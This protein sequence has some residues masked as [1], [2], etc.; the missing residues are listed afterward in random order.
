MRST[1]IAFAVATLPLIGG[2]P[3]SA[4]PASARSLEAANAAHATDISSARKHTQRHRHVHRG[5]R[6]SYGYVR[7]YPRQGYYHG[8][9]PHWGYGP[10]PGDRA[11]PPFHFRPY[12]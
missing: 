1:V 2:V 12:W 4:S 6:S 9:R 7:P 5:V 11:W 8:I 3:A 10:D